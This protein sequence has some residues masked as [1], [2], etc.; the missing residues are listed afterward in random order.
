MTLRIPADLS[1]LSHEQKDALIATLLTRIDALAAQVAALQAENAA[2]SA[3]VAELEAKLTQPPKTPDNSS[4]PPSRGQKRNRPAKMKREGPRVGSLG[5]QGGGRRLAH[6]PDQFVI[7]KP[8]HCRHCGTA[9]V[10]GDHVLQGRYDKVDPGLRRG[11][12]CRRCGQS[13]RG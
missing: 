3:R 6:E 7:A 5:R 2:L 9:L 13:S 12:L 8:A 11:R 4:I 10:A 1:Q